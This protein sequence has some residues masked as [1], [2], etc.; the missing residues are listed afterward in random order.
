MTTKLG[1]RTPRVGP[2]L[3]L[4]GLVPAVNTLAWVS[5]LSMTNITF[6]M[7]FCSLVHHRLSR[8]AAKDMQ[9]YYV[10]T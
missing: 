7:M 5:S 9:R 10:T 1:L 3:N 4:F 6:G 2:L 8:L